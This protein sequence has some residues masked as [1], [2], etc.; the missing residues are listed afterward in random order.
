MLEQGQALLN[1]CPHVGLRAQQVRGPVLT[2]PG[3]KN[4]KKE[5]KKR[6]VISVAR[7]LW[8]QRDFPKSRN[9]F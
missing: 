3:G 5:T 2:L 8:L 4:G 7:E 6:A 9:S 1:G